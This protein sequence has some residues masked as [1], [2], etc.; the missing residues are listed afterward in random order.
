MDAS[1]TRLPRPLAPAALLACALLLLTGC[2]GSAPGS[3]A[4]QQGDTAQAA[5]PAAAN[6]L[7]A[8]YQRVIDDV[9]PS[10]V[11]IQA[12]DS[13]GSG[14]VYDDEGHVVTNAHV[15]GDGRS[16]RVTTAR[17]EEALTARL[18]SSYPEQDLAVLKLD[19]LPEG[20][21]AARFGDSSK[22]EVGQIVLAM[23]SPLGLSS[24]VT[25]GIVSAVGR[26]VTEGRE[27]GGTGATI[28]NMV[29]TSA[30]INPGN[31]GGALVN[32]DSEVIGIPT[33]AAT[34]P[35]LGDS[36][37]P[38]IGFAI[39]AS[40]VRT[41]A[42]QIIRDGRVTDSGR[43]ALGVTARTVV[44]DGYRP[45]GVAVVEVSD[46]GA[47]DDAGLR[48]GDV[49]VRL[50]DTDI[51]TITSLAEALA[52]MRPGDRTKVTYTRDGDERT[53]EVTLGEQ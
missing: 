47:A 4:G 23:G 33:L 3:R 49:I 15:V 40:M 38:G 41:V 17:T 50:G 51:T 19:R 32:L 6:D 20:M 21:K 11:Q 27:G 43:A 39:P 24:S 30:A 28:G 25:Q 13:L 45:A 52:S 42:D 2:T 34:D 36:A 12:G 8:D 1:R 10:V 44:D 46:G 35:G 53:A 16:F 26:T 37:A 18:V 31:S 29:Q 9:L 5:A 48:P 22:A 14:V 7:Q